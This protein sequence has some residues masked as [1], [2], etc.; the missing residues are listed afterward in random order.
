MN[1]HSLSNTYAHTCGISHR[2]FEGCHSYFSKQVAVVTALRA[3]LATPRFDR[4][5]VL[6]VCLRRAEQAGGYKSYPQAFSRLRQRCFHGVLR[7]H[8]HRLHGRSEA[9]IRN[10]R[11]LADKLPNRCDCTQN[12]Q[13]VDHRFHHAPA[14]LF[15]ADQE[16]VCRLSFVLHNF[17]T[18]RRSRFV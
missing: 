12:A 3:V 8:R 11:R 17:K 15:R 13:R 7:H 16:R 2:C 4:S 5:P 14:L 9:F 1:V 10:R 6:R 18:P